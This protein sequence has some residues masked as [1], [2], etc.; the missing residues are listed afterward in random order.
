MR[1][2]SSILRTLVCGLFS[3]GLV[4]VSS[5]WGPALSRMLSHRPSWSVCGQALCDCR[6]ID[7]DDAGDDCPLCAAGLPMP[8]DG[9]DGSPAGGPCG[10]P[11]RSRIDPG[12]VALRATGNE[13]VLTDL[14]VAGDSLLTFL[15]LLGRSGGP[16]SAGPGD[17]ARPVIEV[18]TRPASRDGEVPTPPPRAAPTLG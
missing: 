5:G 12:R 17:A 10:T 7:V 13:R 6:P 8:G 16:G 1:S 18:A 9:P 3:L 14:G 11:D 2:E 15:F 4:L